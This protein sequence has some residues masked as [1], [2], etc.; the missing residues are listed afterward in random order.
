MVL[1]FGGSTCCPAYRFTIGPRCSGFSA[2]KLELTWSSHAYHRMSTLFTE[3][4][5]ST[6]FGSERTGDVVER[7]SR[8]HEYLKENTS[9][10]TINLIG[11][12]MVSQLSLA[13]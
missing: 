12:S 13:K 8:L 2:K 7:A 5:S 4:A 11:H 10:R 1:M 6:Y 3:P 9:G